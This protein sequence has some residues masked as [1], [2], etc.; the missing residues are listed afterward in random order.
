MKVLVLG[1]GAREHAL[2]DALTRSAARPEVLVAPGN[3]GMRDVARPVPAGLGDVEALADLAQREA[4]DLTIAGSEEPLVRGVWDAF[5]AR[6]LRLFGPSRAAAQ[7]EGSKAFAKQFMRRHGI[8]TAGFEIHTDFDTA[9]AG[10]ARAAFPLVV[11]ADG[12]AA[13]KGVHVVPDAAAAEASLRAMLVE[14][15]YGDAG[16]VVVVEEALQG[17]EI[18][19]F[20]LSDGYTFRLLG[21]VQDHKRANDGDRGPNTGG[22]GAYSPVPGL[23]RG[24]LADLE[25]RFLAP[26]LAGAV[27]EGMPYRGFLYLG[28]ML[29]AAGPQLL[30]YNCRLGDPEAQVLLPRLESDVLRLVGAAHAGDVGAAPLEM[31]AE[32][33]VGVVLASEGYPE[34]PRTGRRVRG[35]EAARATGARVYCAGVAGTGADLVTTG[36]RICTV[37]GLGADVAAARRQA[38][39]AVGHLEVE[40]AFYRR[41]IAAR[42]LE[43]RAW[44]HRVSAS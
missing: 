5:D 11:K 10:L 3:D 43:G 6:G 30:E 13:G 19:V 36:G 40:G 41:D 32:A 1:G 28:L 2:A 34:A 27:D 37:V 21:V 15:R 7:L 24:L 22:M 26:T 16:R 31:G 44:L 12:L 23:D 18:S 17:P 14:G 38:Y 35:L 33:A 20:A 39:E 42:A 8:P 25:A 4:V 9:R 29:T